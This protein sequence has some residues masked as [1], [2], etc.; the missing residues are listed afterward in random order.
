M[1]IMDLKKAYDRFKRKVLLQILVVYVLDG[2]LLLN[3]IKSLPNGLASVRVMEGERESFRTD[4]GV[5]CPF[6]FPLR[7]WME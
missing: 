5:S 1:A 2:K 6:V 7:T 3:I 4:E